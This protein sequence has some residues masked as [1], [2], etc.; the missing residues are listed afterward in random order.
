[1][2]HGPLNHAKNG[3]CECNV[4]VA[5]RV[6]L[7]TIER[8]NLHNSLTRSPNLANALVLTAIC[9]LSMH[10]YS[11]PMAVLSRTSFPGKYRLGPRTP[12]SARRCWSLK[13]VRR[14]GEL[15]RRVLGKCD[16]LETL[17]SRLICMTQRFS[18]ASCLFPLSTIVRLERDVL[19]HMEQPPHL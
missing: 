2:V 16:K 17:L 6:L 15:S 5:L 14:S 1:L 19:R 12:R 4:S 11:L 10:N 8:S 9:L 7:G 18:L 13:F 3:W